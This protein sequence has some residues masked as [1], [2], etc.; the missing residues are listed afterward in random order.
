MEL[1]RLA[2][3]IAPELSSLIEDWDRMKPALRKIVDLDALC[4]AHGIA[5]SH[6]IALAG[7]AGMRFRDDASILIA[8][9]NMPSVISASVKRAKSGGVRD[10][11]ML[12][13]LT[14][15]LPLPNGRILN[16]ASLKDQ[17]KDGEIRRSF[18]SFESTMALLEEVD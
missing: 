11:R 10:T 17:P 13:Q 4:E 7:V 1:A 14:G 12:M 9:I 16:L 2:L 15:F 6:L 5:P 8:A 18:P 3:T